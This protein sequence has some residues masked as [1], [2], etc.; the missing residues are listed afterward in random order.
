LLFRAFA[1]SVIATGLLIL[2]LPIGASN[3]FEYAQLSFRAHSPE[4]PRKS[5]FSRRYSASH[6]AAHPNQLVTNMTAL[7]STRTTTPMAKYVAYLAVRIRGSVKLYQTA[8]D[9]KNDRSGRS[10][11][12]IYTCAV[13][14]D[15]GG[16]AIRLDDAGNALWVYL[17]PPHGYGRLALSP[18]CGE[19]ILEDQYELLSGLDDKIFRLE[20][21]QSGKCEPIKKFWNLSERSH[22]AEP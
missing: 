14:C 5:C 4:L 19:E 20:V 12:Q 18:K 21:A 16:F 3:G 10:N 9:C 8:A 17:A 13:E 15:G 7:I 11:A 1:S 6:L 2:V 22:A